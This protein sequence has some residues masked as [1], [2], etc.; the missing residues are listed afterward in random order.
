MNFKTNKN[1]L[2]QALE[3]N[4]LDIVKYLVEEQNAIP[5]QITQYINPN[6]EIIQY[7]KEK[8]PKK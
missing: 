2:H 8:F 4:H 5:K 1:E 3:N 6:K 7:L